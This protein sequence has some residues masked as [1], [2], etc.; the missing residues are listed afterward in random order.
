MALFRKNKKETPE[1]LITTVQ[2][3]FAAANFNFSAQEVRKYALD[4]SDRELYMVTEQIK[5]DMQKLIDMNGGCTYKN[6]NLLIHFPDNVQ[7]VVDF[8]EDKGFTVRSTTVIADN[9]K[10]FMDIDITWD[11][12]EV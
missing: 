11:V 3:A 5:A 9:V 2:E 6:K 10:S 4:A 7:H 1:T 8:F 12:P